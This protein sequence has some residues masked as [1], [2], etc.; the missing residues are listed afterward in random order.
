MSWGLR[1]LQLAT[2]PLSP[3]WPRLASKTTQSKPRLSS[4]RCGQVAATTA[5]CSAVPQTSDAAVVS[6]LP[7]AIEWILGIYSNLPRV[8]TTRCTIHRLQMDTIRSGG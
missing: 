4:A 2:R 5:Q 8:H 3:L 7:L 1:V 6:G